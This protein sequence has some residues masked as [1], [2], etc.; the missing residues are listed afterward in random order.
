MNY[1]V[2]KVSDEKISETDLLILGNNLKQF[3]EQYFKHIYLDEESQL[4]ILRKID[5]IAGL[6]NSRQY[7]Q[8]FDN[9]GQIDYDYNPET[10]LN[11]SNEYNNISMYDD[12]P[13]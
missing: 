9:P 11:H 12:V 6:I 4:E 7:Y 3:V 1:Y 8:L 10:N 2:E 5:F 13:F